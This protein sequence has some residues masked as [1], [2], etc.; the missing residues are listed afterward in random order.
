MT[1]GCCCPR[2]AN[3]E[4]PGPF[5]APDAP[6]LNSGR[7]YRRVTREDLQNTTQTPTTAAASE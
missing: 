4:T 1:A 7:T 6:I 3:G 5:G 2:S